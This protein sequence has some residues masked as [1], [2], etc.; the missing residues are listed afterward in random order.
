MLN[1]GGGYG[2]EFVQ[3]IV[4]GK[5]ILRKLLVRYVESLLC[6]FVQNLTGENKIVR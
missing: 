1:R 4:S 2:L 5:Q 6:E 3:K